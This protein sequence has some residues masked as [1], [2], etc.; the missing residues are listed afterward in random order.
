V[1]SA[2]G[3]LSAAV[4]A[5]T[6]AGVGTEVAEGVMGRSRRRVRLGKRELC[7]RVKE[8]SLAEESRAVQSTLPRVFLSWSW[9]PRAPVSSARVK[10]NV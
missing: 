9:E 2:A 1:A 3:F 7:S 10:L 8:D 4:E 6:T 5:G